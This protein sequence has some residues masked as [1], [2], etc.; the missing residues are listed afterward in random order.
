MIAVGQITES[1]KVAA[2][3]FVPLNFVGLWLIN[4]HGSHGSLALFFVGASFELPIFLFYD[5]LA[6]LLGW[7]K[8]VVLLVLQFCWLWLWSLVGV[9]IYRQF[10]PKVGSNTAPHPNGREAPHSDQPSSTPAGGRER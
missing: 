4:P 8:G 1:L 9:G 10:R 2:I 7:T 3:L 6:P 5:S